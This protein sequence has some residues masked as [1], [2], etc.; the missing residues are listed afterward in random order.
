MITISASF[1]PNDANAEL[2]AQVI[3]LLAS[4]DTGH[5]PASTSGEIQG[6]GGM[7]VTKGKVA[8]T[9][10]ARVYTDEQKAAFRARMIA[11][12]EAKKA[13]GGS[14]PTEPEKV[15]TK[16]VEPVKVHGS[17]KLVKATSSAKVSVL[18]RTGQKVGAKPAAQ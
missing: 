1:Q 14:T 18:P 13:A 10:K 11:A 9:R 6:E 17:K 5:L 15:E 7:V 12:R 3:K 2:I 8:K 4:L 16:S